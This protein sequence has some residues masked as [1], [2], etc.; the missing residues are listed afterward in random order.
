MVRQKADQEDA[1]MYTYIIGV[2]AMGIVVGMFVGLSHS[3]VVGILLPLLF[4]LLAGGSGL[5]VVLSGDSAKARLLGGSLVAFAFT[6]A[7]AGVLAANVRVS[8]NVFSFTA[9]K[10]WIVDD[11]PLQVQLDLFEISLALQMLGILEQERAS[12]IERIKSQIVKFPGELDAATDHFHETV[13]ALLAT[14]NQNS[15]T[16]KVTKISLSQTR[17]RLNRLS[18]LLASPEAIPTN[19]IKELNNLT[20]ASPTIP[21]DKT[22]QGPIRVKLDAFY[23]ACA[24]LKQIAAS[25]PS[26]ILADLHNRLKNI[27]NNWPESHLVSK[28]PPLYFESR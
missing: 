26:S 8:G 1:I 17:E 5:Y 25:H 27:A 16:L 15:E 7:V 2:A 4:T 10:P 9:E 18:A 11:V 22:L 23:V 3:P 13:S 21:Q 20:C 19:L 12:I 24:R 28:K 14:I 6:V